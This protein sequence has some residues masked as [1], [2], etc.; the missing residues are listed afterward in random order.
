M[1]LVLQ[2]I[3]RLENLYRELGVCP[4]CRGLKTVSRS[5]EGT[6]HLDPCPECCGTGK[7]PGLSEL[8]RTKE[9]GN[10]SA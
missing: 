10:A 4:R 6:M 1:N 7:D 8:L 3:R 5:R 2:G 9:Q